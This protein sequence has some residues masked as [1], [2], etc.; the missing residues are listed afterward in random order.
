MEEIEVRFELERFFVVS[1]R[2]VKTAE[3]RE[4]VV[5]SHLVHSREDEKGLPIKVFF[6]LEPSHLRANMGST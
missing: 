6:I 4:R 1:A 5:E 2:S 3:N